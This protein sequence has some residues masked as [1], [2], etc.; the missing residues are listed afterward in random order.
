[1][2]PEATGLKLNLPEG[3]EV[4]EGAYMFTEFVWYVWE[5]L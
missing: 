4:G 2:G 5:L 3:S 1:M